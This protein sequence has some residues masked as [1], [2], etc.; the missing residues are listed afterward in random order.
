MAL[1]TQ[2]SLLSLSLSSHTHALREGHVNI[3]QDGSHLQA[4]R[5][6]LRMEPTLPV[7]SSRFPSLQSHEK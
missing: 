2:K 5:R 4:K 6:G 7:P 1:E 3:Q